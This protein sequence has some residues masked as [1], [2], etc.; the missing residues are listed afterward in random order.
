MAEI[1]AGPDDATCVAR[2]RTGDAEAFEVLA[3]RHYRAA[4]A[5]ALG[6]TGTPMDAED[7]CHDAL[8]RALE[9]LEDCRHPDR[10]GAWLGQIVRNLSLNLL[11][12]R[13]LRDGPSVDD[14]EL[15]R[16]S[17]S[18]DR[19]ERMELRERLEAALATLDATKRQVLLLHDLEGWRHKAIAA[20]LG[21]SEG[22]SRLHLF[23]ARR[24]VRALLGAD[25]LAEYTHD[26]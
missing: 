3:R 18:V 16:P 9:R 1:T 4:Y 24:A 13:S 19:A 6:V 20:Q 12:S 26:R 15:S 5:I 2:A 17:A 7:V 21:C 11:R 23:H 10:F 14:L 8:L 25:L 22:M